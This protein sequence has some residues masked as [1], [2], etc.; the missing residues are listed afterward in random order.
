MARNSRW[1]EV[2][3][4]WEKPNGDFSGTLSFGVL[5]D[6][7]ILL[8]KVDTTKDSQPSHRIIVRSEQLPLSMGRLLEELAP[9]NQAKDDSDIP[10]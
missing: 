8:K 3:V 7:N 1:V 4:L 6:C 9:S 10:F 5:G 2:G